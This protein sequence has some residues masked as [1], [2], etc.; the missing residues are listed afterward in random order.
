[1]DFI[2]QELSKAGI[3]LAVKE[4]FS[5]VVA[6]W[7]N[8]NL[9]ARKL[10]RELTNTEAYMNYLEKHVSRV[11]RLR[12]IHSADY[13]VLLN[14]IYHPLRIT[15]L[16]PNSIPKLIEDGFVFENSNITNIIGIAGQGKSTILRKVFIEQVTHG[17]KIP[18]FI[19]LR[20][21]GVNGIYKTLESILSNLGLK[22]TAIEIEELL[23]CGR[24]VL[25]LDGYDEINSNITEGLLNEML[26]LNI[27]HKVQ[28]I[29]TSRPGTTICNEPTIVNYKVE[30]LKEND[31]L[32][33]IEKLNTHN[34][35]IEKEQLKKIKET[36]KNNRNLVSVMTS[37]ILVTLFHVC[38]PYMDII[39]NNTVEFYSNLFMTLYLRHDK[40]KNF[41]REKSSALG[42]NEAYECFCALCFYSI[43]AN[44]HEFTDLSLH[45]FT[46]KSMR[47]K[48]KEKECKP[49][50]LALDFMNVT[51]LIQK[52]GYNKYI[53]IHKSIQEYHAAEF[54]KH[55]SSDKKNQFYK[56]ITEDIKNNDFR[57]SNVIS[58][59]TEIDDIDCAK[60]F[61]IPLCEHFEISKWASLD[62]IE[63]KELLRNFFVD[64]D[65]V[66]VYNNNEVTNIG[67][68]THTEFNNWLSI[69][70][71]TSYNNIYHSIF[72]FI[73]THLK[74]NEIP[75]ELNSNHKNEVKTSLLRLILSMGI[76]D[77][78]LNTFVD[79][80]IRLHNE[81]YLCAV[82][83]IKNEADSM[84]ELFDFT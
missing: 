22:P 38:Y 54:I 1:M 40:I 17:D 7:D 30:K 10:V 29:V 75:E 3:S 83:K 32:S 39:P 71:N 41:D 72:K 31:I 58:F 28:I 81:L 78:V 35:N 34:K 79:N 33:I 59:L 5:R 8:S 19:E 25:M 80:V 26:Q 43:Y 11:V 51:C 50:S 21:I 52:E 82:I 16:I 60:H 9:N 84:K 65:I 27:K 53:F 14:D 73:F 23:S 63:Y 18:F 49:E 57:F 56:L 77:D 74:N 4:L 20:K 47:I 42:H 12:T 2:F 37:P 67:F 66:I 6:K 70:C 15:S 62:Q 46:E 61:I 76:L 24:I 45:E 55:V 68:N 64:T 13:D 36:I 48:G 69:F 44:N